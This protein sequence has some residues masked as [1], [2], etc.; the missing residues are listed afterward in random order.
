MKQVH[1]ISNS[2]KEKS[3]SSFIY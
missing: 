2:L 1:V 3:P